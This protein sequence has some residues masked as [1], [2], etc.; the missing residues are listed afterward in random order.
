MLYQT[1]VTVRIIVVAEDFRVGWL[2][3][4]WYGE[5]SRTDLNGPHTK[6][7]VKAKQEKHPKTVKHKDP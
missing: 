5:C 6:I 7:L 4:S 2:A 3:V 1:H